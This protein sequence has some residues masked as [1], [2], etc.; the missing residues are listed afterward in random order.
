[1]LELLI[2]LFQFNAGQN[3]TVWSL[4]G[5]H[6]NRWLSGQAPIVSPVPYHVIIEGI[7][8]NTA[9]ADIALDDVDFSSSLCGGRV[10][11]IYKVKL[12]GSKPA[13]TNC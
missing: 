8:G 10:V 2:R 12:N 5:G 13:S 1:M 7:R 3:Q 4:S 6:G 11:D 9:Q